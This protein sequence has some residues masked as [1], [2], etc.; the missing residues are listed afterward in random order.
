MFPAVEMMLGRS[1]LSFPGFLCKREF[2]FQRFKLLTIG[3]CPALVAIEGVTRP[4]WNTHRHA[5]DRL[6]GA[7]VFVFALTAMWPLPS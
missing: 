5:T 2:D 1:G 4:R 3:N 6:V 7:L